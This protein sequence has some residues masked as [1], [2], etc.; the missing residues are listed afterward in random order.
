MWFECASS[1]PTQRRLFLLV[2]FSLSNVF[3][4]LFAQ[5]FCACLQGTLPHRSRALFDGLMHPDHVPSTH[6]PYRQTCGL[7]GLHVGAGVPVRL[8]KA[9]CD[10]L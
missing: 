5:V 4:F 9:A 2:V 1:T 6:A 8:C 7:A 10:A 3:L